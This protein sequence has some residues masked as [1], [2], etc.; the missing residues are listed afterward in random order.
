MNTRNSLNDPDSFCY[1]CDRL[2]FTKKRMKID[3]N[4]KQLYLNYFNISI[5]NQDKSWVPHTACKS[6]VESLRRWNN[7]KSDVP[8]MPFKILVIWREA[9]SPDECF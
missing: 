2:T 9:A 4:G 3:D 5:S 6:C 8:G 1:I 7:S